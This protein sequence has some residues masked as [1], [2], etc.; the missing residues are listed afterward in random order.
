MAEDN[1]K[2]KKDET[3]ASDTPVMHDGKINV[4]EKYKL[5]GKMLDQNEI[6]KI[7]SKYKKK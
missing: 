3:S 6:D 7:V 4:T 2:N 5:G 1:K